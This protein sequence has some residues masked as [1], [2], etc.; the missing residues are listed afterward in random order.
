MSIN[1]IKSYFLI[2]LLCALTSSF[3]GAKTVKVTVTTSTPS[4]G[5]M[6]DGI[7]AGN[8]Q[9][10]T[11]TIDAPVG[12]NTFEVTSPGHLSMKYKAYLGANGPFR[13]YFAL[14][15][16]P[17]ADT[18]DKVVVEK[19]SDEKL[20][21]A[22]FSSSCRQI[23]SMTSGSQRG[24]LSCK[25]K[26]L[27]AELVATGPFIDTESAKQTPAQRLIL[28]KFIESTLGP[29]NENWE[30]LGEKLFHMSAK[31][32]YGFEAAAWAA[33]YG[34]NCTRVSEIYSY[35]K[36]LAKFSA[37]VWLFQSIC[38]EMHEDPK[39]AIATLNEGFTEIQVDNNGAAALYY[40]KARTELASA[41]DKSLA[42]LN[43]CMQK[44]PWYQKCYLMASDL[45]LAKGQLKNHYRIKKRFRAISQ[46]AIGP[47]IQAAIKSS[48]QRNYK[49]ALQTIGGMGHYQK[50]FSAAW[51]RV[52][53]ETSLNNRPSLSATSTATFSNVYAPKSAAEVLKLLERQEN[54]DYLEKSLK[55][56]IRDLP[57]NPYFLW[58][59]SGLYLSQGKC[60]KVL[61]IKL[62]PIKMKPKQESGLLEHKARCH[63]NRKD[64]ASAEKIYKTMARLI[65]TDWRVHYQLG[66]AYFKNKEKFKAIS[67][68]RETLS[69]KP[70]KPYADI[71]N[72]KLD[73]I[74]AN[75]KANGQ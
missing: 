17:T 5:I 20:N 16:L 55:I 41:V 69:L 18:A 56:L 2:S 64:F 19:F 62:P 49:A 47:R 44:F 66:N 52:L 30:I 6:L 67:S 29:Y 45:V 40:H 11:G 32:T 15:K 22:Q 14:H 7:L 51:L 73:E 23:S 46:K 70:P 60:D 65:P 8:T 48:K 21:P 42:T 61:S 9:N 71:I 37:S 74:G 26:N 57:K 10:S 36:T 75:D 4:A 28:E 53:V 35:M 3:A 33:L 43:Q 63:L 72:R 59:L 12:W 54:K 1:K 39:K 25:E 68:Y 13:L 31:G 34:G 58:K 38:Y 27:A 50:S 24:K